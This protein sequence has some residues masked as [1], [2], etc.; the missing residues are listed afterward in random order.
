MKIT[1]ISGFLE[2]GM[3]GYGPPFPEVKIEQIA[4][5]DDHGYEGHKI[6][7]STLSGTYLETAAHR[8]K[9]APTVD[10]IPPKNLIKEAAV[11]K[12]SFHKK[13]CEHIT[14]EELDKSGVEVKE[15]DALLICTGWDKNWN[16]DNFVID[17]PHF[18]EEAT[19][20]IIRKKVSLW[21]AD[22]PCFDDRRNPL[23]LLSKFYKISGGLVL[24]PLVGLEQ[25]DS[26]LVKLI[27]LPLPV[28]GVCAVPSRVL[29]IEDGW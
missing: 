2:N 3:W 12:L 6:T 4:S 11:I 29:V 17:S 16:R 9:G 18:T 25:I 10:K 15:G 8:F 13:P 23:G 22:L 19:D 7:L 27:V 24:A 28:R 20:W 14:V 21:G 5:I 26:S 1:E